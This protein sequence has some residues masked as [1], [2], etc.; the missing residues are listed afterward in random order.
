MSEYSHVTSLQIKRIEKELKQLHENP[1]E[2]FRASPV[3]VNG[4]FSSKE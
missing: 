4:G 3:K 1:P 2:K